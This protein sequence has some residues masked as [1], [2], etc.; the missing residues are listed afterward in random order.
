MKEAVARTE[1]DVW[2]RLRQNLRSSCENDLLSAGFDE[3]LVTLWIGHTVK[4]SRKSY[5][6]LKDSD[7]TDAIEKLRASNA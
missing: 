1:F 4:T 5:Q 3:R 2:G 6:K 7:Y